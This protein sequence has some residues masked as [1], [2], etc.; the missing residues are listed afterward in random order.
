[1]ITDRDPE[2]FRQLVRL[3][4][5]MTPGSAKDAEARFIAAIAGAMQGAVEAGVS[6]LALARHCDT[7][8]AELWEAEAKRARRLGTWPEALRPPKPQDV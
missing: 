1:M 3:A 2:T 5:G 7:F 4:V 6:P 8:G